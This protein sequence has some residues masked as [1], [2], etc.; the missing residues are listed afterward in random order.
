MNLFLDNGELI[1]E[2]GD[3]NA[4]A[5]SSLVQ[6]TIAD[7]G[8]VLVSPTDTTSGLTKP[9][10]LTWTAVVEATHYRLEIAETADTTF[11]SPVKSELLE[12]NEYSITDLPAAWYRW[13]VRYRT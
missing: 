1:Q 7:E 4:F 10:T 2:A 11:A 9:V 8:F 6:E 12:T 3:L 13:R 5:G